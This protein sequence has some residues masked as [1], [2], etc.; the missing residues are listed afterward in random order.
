MEWAKSKAQD[1]IG[2][3]E[4]LGA[5]GGAGNRKKEEDTVMANMG[6]DPKARSEQAQIDKQNDR[7]QSYLS[8]LKK[9]Q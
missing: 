3:I 6:I 2:F 4:E 1:E 5:S 7:L 8:S 9:K